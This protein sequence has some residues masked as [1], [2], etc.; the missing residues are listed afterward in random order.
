MIHHVD[1]VDNVCN[2]LTLTFISLDGYNWQGF[3]SYDANL[4]DRL[5]FY[6]SNLLIRISQVFMPHLPISNRDDAKQAC[7]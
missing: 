3:F 5:G 2:V 7:R 6:L 4:L 1:L